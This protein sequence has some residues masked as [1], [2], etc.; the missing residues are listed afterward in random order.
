MSRR[1]RSIGSI[2]SKRLIECSVRAIAVLLTASL[3]SDLL[4]SAWIN[5]RPVDAAPSR[6]SHTKVP[7]DQADFIRTPA[8]CP[9]DIEGLSEL[10]LRDVPNYGNRVSQRSRRSVNDVLPQSHIL[11]ASTADITSLDPL[12]YRTIPTLE[13]IRAQ[14]LESIFFTTLERQSLRNEAV[15]L[16]HYHWAFLVDTSQGWAL[17]FMY[18][19]LGDYPETDPPTPPRDSNHGVIAQA[20]RLWLRDCEAG[21]VKAP[22]EI[23]L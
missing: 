10:M 3:S 23:D 6:L 1:H 15:L 19:T 14:G 16:Q 11:S 22:E 5:P 4:A 13:E 7:D 17:A 20:I 21:S 12:R 8:L 9:H 18:S 2:G